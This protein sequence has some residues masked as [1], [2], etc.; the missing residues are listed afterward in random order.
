MALL[1]TAPD[2]PNRDLPTSTVIARWSV[3]AML[4]GLGVVYLVMV[5]IGFGPKD[6]LWIAG[7]STVPLAVAL[8]VAVIVW[9]FYWKLD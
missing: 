5:S 1:M 7:I 8:I 4:A 3:L 6:A 9:K 2:S